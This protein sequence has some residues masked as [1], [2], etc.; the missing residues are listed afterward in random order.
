[1]F[2]I[3]SQRE[4]WP[5]RVQALHRLAEPQPQDSTGTSG[6][7]F[8]DSTSTSSTSG[9]MLNQMR[10]D[11]AGSLLGE[12]DGK[13]YNFGGSGEGSRDVAK[14]GDSSSYDCTGVVG[15]VKSIYEGKD[16]YNNY[17]KDNTG[18]RFNTTSDMEASGF[19]PGAVP[20]QFNIGINPNPGSS[21]HASG[22]LPSGENFESSS[23]DGV[24]FGSGARSV[25]DKPFTQ[26]WHMPGTN[27][28]PQSQG[29]VPVENL[30]LPKTSARPKKPGGL[31]DSYVND[32]GLN[33]PGK[34]VVDFNDPQWQTKTNWDGTRYDADGS[35]VFPFVP[36]DDRAKGKPYFISPEYGHP[37][38]W[39]GSPDY[40]EHRQT[41]PTCS[42]GQRHAP[43]SRR[44][45]AIAEHPSRQFIHKL[46]QHIE[47]NGWHGVTL[48]EHPGDAPKS[49]YMVS[50][51]G[52]EQNFPI[53]EL[54]GQKLLDYIKENHE[55]IN[56]D[57]ENY[58]G[59][60]LESNKWYNDVSHHH[61][62][63]KGLFPA[64]TDAFR[65]DQLALYDLD[66]DQGIDTEEAGWMT[67]AP[68]KVGHYDFP[69]GP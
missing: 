33:F 7:T 58:L 62:R 68:W 52:R 32:T 53:D 46:M 67:G 39:L 13:P 56:S 10:N 2:R 59:G 19:K 42:A 25:T 14:G 55:L 64:A 30:L 3:E 48:K 54:S 17:A 18:E 26:Q 29:A 16:P 22:Q 69:Q 65:N 8:T 6:T 47:D 21:G 50:L 24:E 36:F 41:C 35:P 23:S 1:V 31:Y 45:Q 63:D 34:T 40:I 4:Q 20:G 61:H 27:L 28:P 11:W 44:R 57:P 15:D 12:S 60:W 37:K 9:M 5:H 38:G 49:G 66:N 43:V 51:K